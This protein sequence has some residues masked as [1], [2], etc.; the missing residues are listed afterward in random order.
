MRIPKHN[1]KK[2]IAESFS[3]TEVARKLGYK[4]S[5]GG[6]TTF[7]KQKVLEG[8]FDISHFTGQRWNK[9]KIIGYQSKLDDWLTG[10]SKVSSSRLRI[11]LIR[12]GLK[13]DRCERCFRKKWLG[14]LLPLELH[15]I[16]FN[17]QNNKIDNLQIL[18]PNCHS[19]Y[20]NHS[21]KKHGQ[22]AKLEE[23]RCA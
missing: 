13:P 20:P 14:Q 21:R 17:K 11:R 8:K 22:V 4:C 15:H 3:F 9:G 23:T 5:N 1:L 6:A 10:L 12:E 18:C 7:I 2:L 16:D 19:L